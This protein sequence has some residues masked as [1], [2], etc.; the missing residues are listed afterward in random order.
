M[1]V[2][3]FGRTK[4][5]D[6]S[7]PEYAYVYSPARDALAE[8]VL[9]HPHENMAEWTE[10]PALAWLADFGLTGPV[11]R[12]ADLAKGIALSKP[13][14]TDSDAYHDFFDNQGDYL[15][16][17]A[18]A[19]ACMCFFDLGTDEFR[20][21]L[22]ALYDIAEAFVSYTGRVIGTA[23]L[24]DIEREI[25]QV[26]DPHILI[27]PD[28]EGEIG[29]PFRQDPFGDRRSVNAFREFRF[30]PVTWDYGLV[31]VTNED[32][33]EAYGLAC[34]WKVRSELV[35]NPGFGRKSE[36]VYAYTDIYE[37][38]AN[39]PYAFLGER[40]DIGIGESFSG[41]WNTSIRLSDKSREA[42]SLFFAGYEAGLAYSNGAYDPDFEQF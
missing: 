8:A 23:A 9:D 29:L 35:H 11:A 18:A 28:V 37:Y 20:D 4:E 7:L 30:P 27:G 13:F 34:T 15:R 14:G 31:S 40:P 21:H 36:T 25:P 16:D 12:L 1:D 3:Y 32:N 41:E 33:E 22:V 6:P 17:F 38:L 5:W 24:R 42:V 19:Q 10:D 39:T 26:I 2:R